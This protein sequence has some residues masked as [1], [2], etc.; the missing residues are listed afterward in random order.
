MGKLSTY[1]FRSIVNQL[2]RFFLINRKHFVNISYFMTNLLDIYVGVP[3]GSILG[4][5]LF[6]I[7]INNHI[8]I[9]DCENILYADDA[10]FYFSD[11]DFYLCI[12]NLNKLFKKL[13]IWLSD[14]KLIINNGKTKLVLFTSKGYIDTLS[15]IFLN[16]LS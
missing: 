15:I 1:D 13:K 5:L 2:L 12:E 14:N 7:F 4:P 3:Q 6:Y 16:G 11:V 8:S 9:T 10:V